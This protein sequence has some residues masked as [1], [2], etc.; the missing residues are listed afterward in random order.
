M[1]KLR[2]SNASLQNHEFHYR[3]RLKAEDVEKHG[4]THG[5]AQRYTVPAQGSITI[6]TVSDEETAAISAAIKDQ[7]GL[8]IGEEP[9]K[10]ADDAP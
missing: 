7:P 6:D 5:G 3:L 4:P 9:A 2:I 1:A 10:K 8:S